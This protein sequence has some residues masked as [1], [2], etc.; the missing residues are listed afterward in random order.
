MV[1]ALLLIA[2]PEIGDGYPELSDSYRPGGGLESLFRLFVIVVIGYGIYRFL[3][4]HFRA[5]SEATRTA[6]TIFVTLGISFGLAHLTDSARAFP[7]INKK[8]VEELSQSP[9]NLNTATR[10]EIESIPGVGRATATR[11]L[12]ARPFRSLDEVR[13]LRGITRPN[14]EQMRDCI[15]VGDA[16]SPPTV[17]ATPT[18]APIK[19]IIPWQEYRRRLMAD[20]PA[21]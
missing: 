14:W 10:L 7:R 9:I 17:V 8:E 20:T 21:D 3:A 2:F 11:I 16:P 1:V 5:F 13:M 15:T 18:P 6:V 19:G 4:E 12:D